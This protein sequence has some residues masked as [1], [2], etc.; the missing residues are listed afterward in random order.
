MILILLVLNAFVSCFNAWS[1]GRG[2]NETRVVGGFPRFMSWMGATMSAVG[3]SWCYLVIAAFV[4][5]PDCLNKLPEPYVAKMFGLGYLALVVPLIG[6]GIAITVDSWAYFWRRRTLA[7]GAI[8]GYNTLADVYNIYQAVRHVPG[9]WDGAKDL[10]KGS[11]DEDEGKAALAKLAIGLAMLAVFGG[12]ITAALII[13][14]VA[15]STATD[16]ALRYAKV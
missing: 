11:S 7:N 9:A 2:W 12:V 14:S 6:S 3:F 8:A 16:R 5:G 13:K 4:A 15:K 1:V 10:F